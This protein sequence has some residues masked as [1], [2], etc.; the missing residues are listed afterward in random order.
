MNRRILKRFAFKFN[1][2]G[3]SRRL[4]MAW[5]ELQL[6]KSLPP[7]PYIVPFDR[8]VLDD[9]ESRVIGFTTKYVTGGTLDNPKRPFRFEYLQQLTRLIDFLNLDLGVM[10]QDIAPRNV[11]VDPQ[12]QRL[13]LFDFDWAANGEKGLREGRD[14]VSGLMFTLYELITGDTQFTL[15]PH[16]DRNIDMVQDISEWICKR[17]L[18]SDVLTFRSFLNEWVATRRVRNGMERYLNA[19]SRLT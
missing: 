7:Y 8:V 9:S 14:D 5:D 3:K 2:I 12:T 19:P 18:D 6:Y 1:P 10:H 16:W 15:I 11:L 13:L 4:Q 17:E